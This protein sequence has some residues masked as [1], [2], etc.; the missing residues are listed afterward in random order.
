[1]IDQF[2]ANDY[3]WLF[4]SVESLPCPELLSACVAFILNNQE[5]DYLC[6][7]SN[8]NS[9]GFIQVSLPNVVPVE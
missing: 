5:F 3:D 6:S 1:M 7:L 2:L 4:L 9:N 8:G